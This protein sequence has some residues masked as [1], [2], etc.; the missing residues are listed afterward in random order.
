MVRRGRGLGFC[1]AVAAL[2]T[3]SLP[4][5]TARADDVDDL[6]RRAARLA[7]QIE[8]VGEQLDVLAEDYVVALDEADQLDSDLTQSQQDVET[9]RAELDSVRL[10]LR[11]FAVKTY[12]SGGQDGG[13][14]GLLAP[15]GALT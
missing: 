8:A 3:T 1:V 9:K 12:A 10:V 5:V 13:F 6:Q 4:A 2:L 14:G 11:D 15:A 7:D